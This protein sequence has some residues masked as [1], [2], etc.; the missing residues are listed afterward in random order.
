M[1]GGEVGVG[2]AGWPDSC[3]ALQAG[4]GSGTQP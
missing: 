4:F 1:N 2:E 3:R